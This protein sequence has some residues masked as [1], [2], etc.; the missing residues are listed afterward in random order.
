[1]AR[2]SQLRLFT[3]LSGLLI[4]SLINFIFA[5]TTGINF[6]D[7]GLPNYLESIIVAVFS[8]ALIG[9]LVWEM[10]NL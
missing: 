3:I 4:F 2:Y 5:L 6:I 8:F 9:L 1:M 10:S 7:I